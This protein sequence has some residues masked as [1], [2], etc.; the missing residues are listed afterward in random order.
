M[1]ETG[2]PI[3]DK[4][5]ALAV[6]IVRLYQFLTVEKKE[7]VLSKQILRSGTSIGANIEESRGAQ[8]DADFYAKIAIAYKEAR[9]TMYW[10][11]LLLATE[12]LTEEQ[13]LSLNDDTNEVCKILISMQKTLKTRM[14]KDI[15]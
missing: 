14:Q 13:F 8:S 3:L 6:R 7:F 1:L 9:E 12:Y 4:S 2:N 5:F 15:K 11:R 10:L